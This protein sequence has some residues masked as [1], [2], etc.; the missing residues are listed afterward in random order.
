MMHLQQGKNSETAIHPN[1]VLIEI[2]SP[3]RR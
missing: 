3:Q 1:D 2:R